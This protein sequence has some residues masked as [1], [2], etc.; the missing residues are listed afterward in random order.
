M[1]GKPAEA[2][3][4]VAEGS[5]PAD[6]GGSWEGE[7]WAT[8]WQRGRKQPARGNEAGG[9]GAVQDHKK[10]HRMGCG[11]ANAGLRRGHVGLPVP[12]AQAGAG[13]KR[14]AMRAQMGKRERGG[15]KNVVV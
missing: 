10:R 7:A 3:G 9:R 5:K 14:G 11:Q 15:E 13:L 1:R 4:L 6:E 2:R 12:C 8:P